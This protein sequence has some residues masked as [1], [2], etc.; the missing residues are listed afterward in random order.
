[1]R[2]IVTGTDAAANSIIAGFVSDRVAFGKA[3]MQIVVVASDGTGAAAN[4]IAGFG[5]DRC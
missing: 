1:M 3:A 2:I 4:I 5:S